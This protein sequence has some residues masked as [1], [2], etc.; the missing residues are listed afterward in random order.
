MYGP[1]GPS[2]RVKET[3]HCVPS[4]CMCF[5]TAYLV[6]PVQCINLSMA[7]RTYSAKHGICRLYARPKV[8]LYQPLSG[9]LSTLARSKLQ[10]QEYNRRDRILYIVL[11]PTFSVSYSYY[12]LELH[13]LTHL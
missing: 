9:I 3:G 7:G 12:F 8:A 1:R 6:I 10:A 13:L 11:H 4:Y 5:Y 2:I